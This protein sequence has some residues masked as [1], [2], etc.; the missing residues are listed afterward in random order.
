LYLYP[1]LIQ[2]P[3]VSSALIDYDLSTDIEFDEKK[4]L[5]CQ[6]RACAIYS[7]MLRTGTVEKYMGSMAEFEK[8]YSLRG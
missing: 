2:H 4:G 7:Y 8:I 1:A 3:E 5:N 6:A